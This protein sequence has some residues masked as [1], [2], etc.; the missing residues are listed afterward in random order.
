MFEII[1]LYF[2][3]RKIGKMAV[4][5]GLRPG[6]WKLYTILYWILFECIGCYLAI[7]LFGFSVNNIVGLMA[8]AIVSAFGGYLLVRYKLENKEPV[9]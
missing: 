7:S 8:F 3:C 1:L 4:E 6:R 9:I 5:K 2:L